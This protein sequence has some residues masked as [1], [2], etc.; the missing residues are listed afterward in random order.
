MLVKRHDLSVMMEI[1]V[2]V[3]TGKTKQQLILLTSA[4]Y[5]K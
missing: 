2:F 1:N 3:C 5:F 4:K